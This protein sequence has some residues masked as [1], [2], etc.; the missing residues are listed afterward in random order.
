MTLTLAK[1][2][3][4]LEWSHNCLIKLK[5]FESD[6]QHPQNLGP[7]SIFLVLFSNIPLLEKNRG[8]ANCFPCVFLDSLSLLKVLC[9]QP[10]N[11]SGPEPVAKESTLTLSYLSSIRRF[12]RTLSLF[13]FLIDRALYLFARLLFFHSLYQLTYL[14]NFCYSCF[15]STFTLLWQRH[16]PL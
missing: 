3:K 5:I 11:S 1:K 15:D 14:L 10:F 2:T 4:T 12:H 7:K 16:C 6:I 8:N 9:W 13:S